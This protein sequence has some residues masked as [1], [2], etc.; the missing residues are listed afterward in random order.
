M[1]SNALIIAIDAGATESKA[2]L[3]DVFG[4]E[5]A[6]IKGDPF[7][8]RQSNPTEFGY[9]VD[10]LVTELFN[11]ARHPGYSPDIVA[12]GAAGVG[13]KRDRKRLHDSAQTIWP[14][15]RIL[16]HHDAFIAHYGA[17]EGGPGVIVTAGTGS[18]A[19]GRNSEGEEARIGGWGWM[20]GDEGS[21][22]WIGR[23]AVRAVLAAWEGTGPETI[24]TS[25]LYD[26]FEVKSA[27]EMVPL[28]YSENFDRL[29]IAKIA[30][31]VTAA[32]KKGDEASREILH[33][34]GRRLGRMVT[35]A[36]WKLR[37]QPSELMIACMGSVSKAAREFIHKAVNIE[38]DIYVKRCEEM[39]GAEPGERSGDETE[40]DEG[41]DPSAREEEQ[42]DDTDA[43]SGVPMPD[44]P[45]FPPKNT[46]SIEKPGPRIVEAHGDALHGAASWARDFALQH[47]FA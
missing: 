28:F 4:N 46:T 33:W 7:N 9:L 24:L 42:E 38:I 12:V 30:P 26:I 47:M 39:P 10:D 11:K 25:R 37:I 44:M 15:C 19:Y 18:I 32:A 27:Y 43:E 8:L 6:T 14:H 17:F 45:Q 35:A 34:A 40:M 5:R 31:E 20:L 13:S 16:V 23:E 1:K 21:G 3:T 36:A 22:Y 29:R 2:F 41:S